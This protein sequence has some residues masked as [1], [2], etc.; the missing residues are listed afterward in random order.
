MEDLSIGLILATLA[1]IRQIAPR[2]NVN[3]TGKRASRG[4]QIMTNVE[5]IAV[6]E[7]LREAVHQ[8]ANTLDEKDE[9]LAYRLG[10]CRYMI[11]QI[12]KQLEDS[13]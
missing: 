7:R 5:L 2:R 4:S 11:E 3:A 6:R 1:L 8:M 10:L 12:D 13:P 9:Q